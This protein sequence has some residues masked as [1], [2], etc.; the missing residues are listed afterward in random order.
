MKEPKKLQILGTFPSGGTISPEE[1]Q[2]A[3]NKY[4]DE[5][6]IEG[7]VEFETDRTLTLKDGILSVNTT[8]VVEEN[9]TLP[10]TSAAVQTVV[11]NIGAILD[12]I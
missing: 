2:T 10:I 8:D 1:I 7:G 12:T 11:G 4:L 5:N 9:N 6:P 3:V